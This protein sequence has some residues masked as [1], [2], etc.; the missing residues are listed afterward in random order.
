MSAETSAAG[1]ACAVALDGRR[2]PGQF[3][4]DWR[5]MDPLPGGW[6]GQ[7]RHL[8]LWDGE[9]GICRRIAAWLARRDR[10]GRLL[11]LAY[12]EVPNPPLDPLLRA[13][14]S[15]AM[16]VVSREGVRLRAG[17]AAIFCLEQIGWRWARPFRHWPL[18]P[19]TELGYRLVARN[20]GL[21]GRLLPASKARSAPGRE[22]PDP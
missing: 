19:L 13:D 12:Q 16:Q 14:S 11:V 18:L 2:I 20:R 21:I 1:D 17:R 4:P 22:S 10:K 3:P 15:R 6:S 9:C 5:G 8:V 7:A